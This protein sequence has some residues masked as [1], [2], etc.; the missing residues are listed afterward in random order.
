MKANSEN[1]EIMLMGDFNMN[2]LNYESN[3]SV[4]DFLDTM[5]THGF[6]P[7][8]SG[9]TRLTSYSK[10]LIDN[11]FYSG[12][13]NDNQSGNILTNI[14]DHLSQILFLP[15]KKNNNTNSNIYQRNFKNMDVE[16]FQDHLKWIDWNSCLEMKLSDTNKSFD[17]F[18]TVVNDLLDTYALY[19]NSLW[20]KLTW[21]TK[22]ILTSIKAN[23]RLYRKFSRS[24]DEAIKTKYIQQIQNL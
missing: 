17:K 16:C 24:K 7:C 3:E 4:A 11:I 15:S 10:T 6:L 5:C 8:T 23:N 19:K 21:L 2:L 20:E 12:I 9:P 13:S 1:K 22:D 14:S 18:F